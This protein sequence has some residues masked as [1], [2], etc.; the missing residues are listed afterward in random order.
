MRPG[1]SVVTSSASPEDQAEGRTGVHAADHQRQR[2]EAGWAPNRPP[3]WLLVVAV[4][5]AA[6]LL[7]VAQTSWFAPTDEQAYW[8]AATRLAEGQPVYSTTSVPG[9]SS[10][11]YWYPPPLVQ[12]LAP[13]TRFVSPEAF[14][15]AWTLLLLLCLWWLAGR[16]VF[17]G[18][19]LIAF[20]PVAVELRSRNIHLVL[21]V[22]VVLALRRSWAFWVPATAIKVGPVIGIVYLAAARRWREAALVVAL[23]AAV[24]AVSV[25]LSPGLW[26]DYVAVVGAQAGTSG[27]SLVPIPYPLRLA[28]AAVLAGVAG[29]V[30][31][32][33]GEV[34][35]VVAITLANPTLWATAL[36]L[37]VAIVPLVR[38]RRQPVANPEVSPA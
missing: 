32:W 28:V 2:R 19:A 27:A 1:R 25:V 29:R 23:G 22:L 24:L 34:L 12:V 16:S 26:A 37:L 3:V 8:R 5:G 4:I 30:D 20:L 36:S 6:L 38:T 13:F 33:R 17:V 15:V 14:T 7:S 10:Y 18:L 9:D 21:A 31:G 11:G 35:V